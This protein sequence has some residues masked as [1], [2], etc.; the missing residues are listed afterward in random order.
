M[1]VRD[2]IKILGVHLD[3]T[4]SI[5]AQ[6]KS[7]MK[8]SNFHIRALRHV[9]RGLTFESAEMIVLGFV[10]SRLD[11]CNS[12]LYIW[13]FKGEHQQTPACPERSRASCAPSCM[14]LQ[15]KTLAQ[16]LTLASSPAEDNIQDRY[17]NIQ[18]ANF[19][20]VILSPQS[21]GQLHTFT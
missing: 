3:P 17:R 20:T 1:E 15:F 18:R 11:Y 8:T 4:L 7:L 19:R 9:R 14:E 2:E 16:I 12:L 5:N 13:H 10:T 6:V 21:A